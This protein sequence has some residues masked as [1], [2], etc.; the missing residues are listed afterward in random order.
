L[1]EFGKKP[2]KKNGK[3]GGEKEKMNAKH[4]KILKMASLLITA[5][6]IASAS[7]TIYIHMYTD[8]SITIG[9][10]LLVWVAGADAPGD[11]GISGGTVTMDLDVQPGVFQ[12]F[13]E[14]LFLRNDDSAAHN[15]TI[16]VT[17]ALTGSDFDTADAKIYENSTGSWAYVDTLT[18]TTADDQYS[19]YTGNTPLIAGGFYRFT[20]EIQADAAASGTKN[21][22]LEVIYE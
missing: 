10:A 5:T 14:A 20:F 22:D 9:S 21:F 19:T 18:L 8:G 2:L 1:L 3:D 6:I 17:T 16:T 12:N 7:A 15:L 11:I 4:S 13:S